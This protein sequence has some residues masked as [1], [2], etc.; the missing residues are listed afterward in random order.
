GPFRNFRAGYASA[1]AMIFFVL[2]IGVTLYQ[3]RASDR[4]VQYGE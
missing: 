4:W 2:I 1:F 3:F